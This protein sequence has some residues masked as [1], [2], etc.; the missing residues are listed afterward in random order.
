MTAEDLP[1][2]DRA[3]GVP[4]PRH[5]AE[6]F[7]QQAAEAAFLQS[8]RQGRLHHAWLLTGPRGIGKATLAWHIARYL[9]AGDGAEGTG[10]G[11]FGDAPTAPSLAVEPDHPVS[12]RVAALT[13]P[14]L[15]LIRRPWNPETKRLTQQIPVDEV[16]RLNGFFR[17]SATEGGRRVVI[18]DSADEMNRAAANAILKVLEEPP[19]NA[20]LLLVSH[21]PARLLPTIRSRCREIRL[22]PLAPEALSAALAQAGVET[23]DSKALHALSDGSAGTAA[24]LA[25]T[26]G[27]ALYRQLL[28]LL[29][30]CPALDRAGAAAL[31]ARAAAGRDDETLALFVQLLM[32]ALSRLAIAGTGHAPGTG[33]IDA[34]RPVFARL[35]PDPATARLWAD[36]QQDLSQ[37]LGHGISVNIDP[38]SLL[39]DAFFRI[40]LLARSLPAGLPA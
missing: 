18:V 39:N 27:V 6:L 35:A 19:K 1:E 13:D 37:R 25:A 15:L 3:E 11:L 28:G 38:Q 26:G 10:P 31:A 7:G 12:R 23:D 33:L 20:V 32:R 24:R 36:L 2:A 5:T 30:T 14:G 22:A 40:E 34:E 8:L 16:R 17:L 29:G 9:L 21:Q 4:H